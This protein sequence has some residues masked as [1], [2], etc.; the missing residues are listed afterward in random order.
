MKILCGDCLEILPTLDSESVH[1][2]VTDP[3]YGIHFMGKEWDKVRATK[4]AKSQ[5]VNLGTGMRI[6]TEAENREYQ[7]WCTMWAGECLR[8]LKPGG[9][10][11]AFGATRTYGRLQCGIEDAGFEIR[12]T[13]AWLYG[14][15]FPKSLDVS[16]QIDKMRGL[17][18]EIIGENPN[19]RE[20]AGDSGFNIAIK[21]PVTKPAS[22]E[23]KEWEG[24]G[25]AL[26]PAMELIVVARKPVSEKTVAENVL[27]HGTGGLNI[28]AC[29]IPVPEGDSVPEFE[30]SGEPEQRNTY[31]KRHSK[32]ARTGETHSRGRYPANVAHDGS[33]QVVE[34]F[35]E[36]GPG[37]DVRDNRFRNEAVVYSEMGPRSDWDSYG[38]AGSASRFF[39]CSK[40]SKS[41]REAGLERLPEKDFG[42]SGGAQ[43]AISRGE[44]PAGGQGFGI[45]QVKKRR[46][47]HPTVKPVELMRWLVKLVTPKYGVVLDPF[48]GS[49]T[50]G[51][52]T[53]IDGF[54]FVGIEKDEDYIEIAKA[55]IANT[56][57]EPTQH[58]LF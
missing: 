46:N 11:L 40:A 2:V 44:E 5:L 34:A 19:S 22:E 28:D 15:G 41:E 38:D 31:G 14:S 50:T 48:M 17:E 23:A 21:G 52:A 1:S 26:K 55:R 56:Y 53:K 33:E 16:K 24:W 39:Y 3:P 7:E 42:M 57:R 58:S 36:T 12:D 6:T 30:H 49:G 4:K 13:I 20:K 35:P 51:M 45:N 10:L 18:R 29:R 27:K 32:V 37:G 25:T 9:Y 43:G 54:E 8:M 47:D